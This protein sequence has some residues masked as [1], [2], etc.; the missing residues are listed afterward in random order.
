MIHSLCINFGQLTFIVT[1]YGNEFRLY[2]HR[3]NLLVSTCSYDCNF[4][5]ALG[6]VIIWKAAINDL[7]GHTELLQYFYHNVELS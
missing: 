6:D 2:N 7:C 4:V 1:Y 3:N 5:L